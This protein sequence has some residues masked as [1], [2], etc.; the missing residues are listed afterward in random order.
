MGD[1]LIVGLN[2]DA[3]V[4]RLKGEPRPITSLED[5]IQVLSALSCVDHIVVF[6]EDTPAN[7]IQAVRPDVYVKG[8]DYTRE[9]LPEV[10][11][12]EALGGMVQILPYVHDHS[13]TSIIERIRRAYAWNTLELKPNA[14]QPLRVNK[15]SLANMPA[16]RGRSSLA[17]SGSSESAHEF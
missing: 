12:V 5:R 16:G 10:A 8:G 3:S 13:T 14:P 6:E 7:L 11:L 17:D 1:V 2:S 4:R 9:T 15:T